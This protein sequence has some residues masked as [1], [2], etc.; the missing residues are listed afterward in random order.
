[1]CNKFVLLLLFIQS[2]IYRELQERFVKLRVL[3]FYK[4]DVAFCTLPDVTYKR[5]ICTSNLNSRLFTIVFNHITFNE[6]S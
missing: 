5:T 3:A 2:S 1:M 6:L 4:I